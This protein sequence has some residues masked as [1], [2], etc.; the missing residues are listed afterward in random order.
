MWLCL[1]PAKYPRVRSF[2]PQLCTLWFDECQT[3]RQ[4]ARKKRNQS[5][6]GAVRPVLAASVHYNCLV[7]GRWRFFPSSQHERISS[8]EGSRLSVKST[9][10]RRQIIGDYLFSPRPCCDNRGAAGNDLPNCHTATASACLFVSF[11]FLLCVFIFLFKRSVVVCVIIDFETR[12]GH[13]HRRSQSCTLR[14]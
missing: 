12:S 3:P 2:P 5:N 10:P 1:T 6:N 11:F 7:D 8:A 14:E 13:A 9:N 4:Y